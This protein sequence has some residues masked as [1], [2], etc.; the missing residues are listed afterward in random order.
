MS[1]MKQNTK[2][3]KQTL[4]IAQYG[5]EIIFNRHSIDLFMA[6]YIWT[7]MEQFKAPSDL[8]REKVKTAF[9]SENALIFSHH[10]STD[11]F[12][13]ETITTPL[14]ITVDHVIIVTQ[15]TSSVDNF[16]GIVRTVDLSV[17]L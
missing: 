12:E 8:S 1:Y 4:E 7:V 9:S 2:K 13:N 6:V 11:K 3:G 5:L 15:S 17:E 16:S 14:R 10:A